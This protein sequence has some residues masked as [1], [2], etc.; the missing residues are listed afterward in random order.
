MNPDIIGLLSYPGIGGRADCNMV[1]RHTLVFKQLL[2]SN[3][4]WSAPAPDTDD[5]IWFESRII[6]P[7]CQSEGVIE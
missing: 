1:R 7:M 6:N 5:I 2:Y 4:N 3:S